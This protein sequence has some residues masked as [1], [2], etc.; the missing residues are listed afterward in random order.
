MKL[1][2]LFE[3][4]TN[5]ENKELG[6]TPKGRKHICPTCGK[7]VP[8]D[9]LVG[10]KLYK[11]DQSSYTDKKELAYD[12]AINL[13]DSGFKTTVR[14]IGNWYWTYYRED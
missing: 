13:Q 3:N 7:E 14:K 11:L 12:Y 2:G 10:E 5:A 9:V 1:A 6:R 4:L 8:T